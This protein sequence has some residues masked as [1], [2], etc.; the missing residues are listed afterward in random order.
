MTN[1]YERLGTKSDDETSTLIDRSQ[2]IKPR[3]TS[4]V[5][6]RQHAIYKDCN[7]IS[8]NYARVVESQIFSNLTLQK[9]IY[10]RAYF[11]IVFFYIMLYIYIYK[12]IQHSYD[13]LINLLSCALVVGI[14]IWRF[15]SREINHYMALGALWDWK[16]LQWLL[17]KYKGNGNYK[18]SRLSFKIFHS[19]LTW[20]HSWYCLSSQKDR[21]SRWLLSRNG[22]QLKELS[23]SSR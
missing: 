19:F 12:V 21:S 22:F 17:W 20:S 10:Y 8:Y 18:H 1:T 5:H 11:S 4:E 3:S 6:Q 9:L 15:Q 16:T 7:Y 14:C 13:Y 23:W 2:T